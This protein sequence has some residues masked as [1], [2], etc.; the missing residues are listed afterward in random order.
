MNRLIKIATLA[1]VSVFFTAC[2]SSS[3]TTTAT[4]QGDY[5]TNER[6]ITNKDYKINSG[7]EIEKISDDPTIEVV[8]DLETGITTAKLISGEAAIIKH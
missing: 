8:T 6:M 2:G 4:S 5:G 3:S 1:V 7:D